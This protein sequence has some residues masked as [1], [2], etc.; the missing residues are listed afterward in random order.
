MNKQYALLFF[1][2]L[3]NLLVPQTR[4]K[5]M[6]LLRFAHTRYGHL[7]KEIAQTDLHLLFY[8][9]VQCTLAVWLCLWS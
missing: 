5:K 1:N 4:K 9:V 2:L 6:G 3:P 7:S 8:D